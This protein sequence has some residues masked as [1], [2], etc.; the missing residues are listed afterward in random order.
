MTHQLGL[1]VRR[2]RNTPGF[3][4]IALT[5]LALGMGLNI[6]I[7]SFTSPA[8]FKAMPYPEPDRLLDVSMAPPGKPE[9]KGVVTPA[10]YLLLRDKTSAAFEAV[11]AFDAGRSANL[12]GD[13]LGPAVRLDGHRISATGLAALGATPLM[14]RLPVAADEQEG[15]A[16]TMVLSYPVW[17]RRFAG[18]PDIVGQTVQ[19]DGQPTQIIG[20][21]PEGFGLLDN[22][23]DAWFTFGFE[24]RARTGDTAQ[25]SRHRSLEAGSLDGRGPGRGEGRT[26]RVRAEVPEP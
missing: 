6:L 26:R 20:V 21:M 3:T 19:V 16:P 25:P 11:G 1:A 10:L 15:A 17:Q 12:A 14:G 5:S 4:A 13:A 18:R 2:L 24:P 23:S 22:S 7:F 8:L 9:S